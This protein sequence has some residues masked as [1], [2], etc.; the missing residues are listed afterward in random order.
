MNEENKITLSDVPEEKLEDVAGGM[1]PPVPSYTVITTNHSRYSSG[2]TPKY[3]VGQHVKV[4]CSTPT[5]KVKLSCVI[6]GVSSTANC[7]TFCKEFGYR[8]Q[9]T[10]A[11]NG[12]L[13]GKICVGVYESC[14]YEN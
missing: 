3:Y 14:L 13:D 9:I 10:E 6:L 7:G 2:D 11:A 1:I 12:H 4:F 8:I 5:G